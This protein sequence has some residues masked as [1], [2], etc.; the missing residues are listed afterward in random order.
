MCFYCL[1]GVDFV[2]LCIYDSDIILGFEYDF[3][4]VLIYGV[5]VIGCE[6]VF[7]FK[8]LGVKVDLVNICDCLFVFMDVEILDVLSYYFWNSGIV[9]CYNEE[10][11]RVEIC[12]DCVVMYLKLGKWV[13]VDCILFVNGCIGNIDMLNFEVVGLKVDGCG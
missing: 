5:G 2:Y 11:D 13:K 1:F 12:D 8:G 9:I 4:C 3:Y 6:Y 7:I 10:F